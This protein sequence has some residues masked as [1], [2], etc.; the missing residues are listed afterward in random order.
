MKSR[1]RTGAATAMA[2]AGFVLSGPAFAQDR[3]CLD[4]ES[5]Q[6]YWQS[7]AEA[8]ITLIA[9]SSEVA[10]AVA[11]MIDH[12]DVIPVV[13]D[14]IILVE[15]PTRAEASLVVGNEA[16]FRAEATPELADQLRKVAKKEPQGD[17][18]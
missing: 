13:P 12:G 7:K 3:Q 9:D 8:R 6:A 11:F 17:L 2:L 4:V 15:L 14:A 16:C 10:R 1:L 18:L 5:I